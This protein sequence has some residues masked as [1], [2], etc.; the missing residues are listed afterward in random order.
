MES[1]KSIGTA[2]SSTHALPLDLVSVPLVYV[3]HAVLATKLRLP[4]SPFPSLTRTAPGI[5][6]FL[7]WKE[8]QG[9]PNHEV[10]IPYSTLLKATAEESYQADRGD[11][12]LIHR[13]IV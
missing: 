11:A 13:S 4:R 3:V 5:G 8:T 6:G 10:S 2:S 12:D 7:C 9:V 1:V